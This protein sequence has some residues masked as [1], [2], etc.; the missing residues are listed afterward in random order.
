[1]SKIENLI[2]S[3]FDDKLTASGFGIIEGGDGNDILSGS[4]ATASYQGASKGVT[5]S[6][7]TS[8]QQDTVGAGKDTLSG[9]RDLIGSAFDDK[10][11]GNTSA[12]TISGGAGNDIIDAGTG[13]A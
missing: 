9:F 10:L 5:V 2:G 7:A 4:S 6:L 13:F 12:N 1:V 11:T 8:S 3:A